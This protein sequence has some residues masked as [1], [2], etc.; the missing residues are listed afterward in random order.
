MRIASP[1]NQNITAGV[2]MASKRVRAITVRRRHAPPG[3]DCIPFDPSK[4]KVRRI[5]RRWK[6]VEGSHWI[7]DFKHEEW[8]AYAALAVIKEHGF[9]SVCFV[10]RP[11]PSM[12][13]FLAGGQAA[14]GAMSGEDAVRFRPTKIE[15]KRILNR[16]TIVDG[17]LLLLDFAG[18]KAEA[19]TALAILK[20]YRFNKMCFVG[21]PN[22]SMTYF[23]RGK[24]AA[25]YATQWVIPEIRIKL[26]WNSSLNDSR[27]K[28]AT[29]LCK[30][31]NV[32]LFDATDG[33]C[34]VSKFT[35]YDK[36]RSLSTTARGVGH[37]YQSGESQH[38]HSNGRPHSPNHFH[39]RLQTNNSK[40]RQQAGTMFMEWCHSYTGTRDEYETINGAS[41][42][43]PSSASVRNTNDACI[44]Y[45]TGTYSELCR[46]GN[47][48]PVTEQG[49]DRDMSCYEW[50]AKVMNAA[51]KGSW[52]VPRRHIPGPEDPIAPKFVFRF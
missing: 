9:D 47:H 22:P 32:R 45:R 28:R 23:L 33:Q 7:L 11:N 43:C 20:K 29:D 2:H 15:V 44:M 49:Q 13:Y 21:R 48:N 52:Q 14:R 24:R 50:I 5:N 38:G 8:E 10:G 39:V 3:E 19:T 42:S 37:I 51:G 30:A 25:G 6:I 12:T 18:N 31:F 41:A 34:R 26:D 36:S 4:I 40:L 1:A 46:S 16:W 35:M 27:L 17:S